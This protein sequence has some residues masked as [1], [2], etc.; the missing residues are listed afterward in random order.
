MLSIQNSLARNCQG[1]TRRDLLH[2]GGLGLLGLGLPE[3]LRRQAAAASST[4]NR[5]PTFGKAK[6]CLII[7]LNGGASHHDTWDMKLD[8]PAEIRGE[9]SQIKSNVPGINMCEHLPLMAKQ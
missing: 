8:A 9:F 2:V 4:T 1:V 6:S 3:L 7:F 5:H